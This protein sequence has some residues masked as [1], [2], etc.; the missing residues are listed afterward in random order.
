MASEV[1][2]EPFHAS[3][4]T[5]STCTVLCNLGNKI[6]L[7][8]LTRFVP[9]YDINAKEL[10][11]K[12]GGIYNMEFYG[13]CARGETMT[14]RIKDEFNNQTT[15]KI[16]YWGFRM[17]NVKIFRNGKLQMTGLKYEDEAKIIGNILIN[18]VNQVKIPIHLEIDN[19]IN[20]PATYDMQLV[21]NGKQV[22]YFRRFYNRFLKNFMFNPE[23]LYIQNNNLQ[24]I[25][26][27]EGIIYNKIKV[28][29]KRK[30]FVKGLHDVYL[31]N[32]EYSD[33]LDKLK[34]NNWSCD[35][36]ILEVIDIINFAKHIFDKEATDILSSSTN[37][38]I[39]RTHLI[40]LKTRYLDFKYPEL[41]NILDNIIK[42]YYQS[43]DQTLIEVKTKV[44]DIFKEYKKFLDK[45][46]NRLMYIRNCDVSIC[47]KITKY[48]ASNSSK[49][50]KTTTEKENNTLFTI[51]MSELENNLLY[52]VSNIETVMIN[53]DLTVNY[54]IN[55]KKMTNQLKKKGLF[56]TYDPDE[57]S[58]VNLKY[59]WNMNNVIQGFC[60][61]IPHC[62]TKEKKS[63]CSKIT[64]LIFRPGSIIITGS[65]TIKQLQAAHEFA[66]KILSE[67]MNA[68]RIDEKLDD[69]KLQALI[70]NENRKISRKPRL[71]FIK[72]DKIKNIKNISFE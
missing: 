63:I 60:N 10:N 65:R 26:S 2:V 41:N 20:A 37:L 46:I 36:S 39:L 50:I 3:N 70:N 31:D 57:H 34:E 59:Y 12:N 51:T 15:I 67:T 4:L 6:N 68:V 1:K 61:C 5:I 69:T 53:S 29:I 22:N 66:I 9:I 16:K 18:I 54:N 35:K 17:I 55:L 21:W 11:D 30:N 8:S 40:K 14:D 45:K 47:D 13:N 27:K 56:N 52:E 38:K 72:K 44:N 28:D 48:L 24:H 23:E 25:A 32:N 64:I 42:E 58:A 43:D 7:E 62:S 33:K 71:F 49:L 19:I